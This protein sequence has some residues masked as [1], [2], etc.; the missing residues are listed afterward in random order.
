MFVV[1]LQEWIHKLEVGQGTRYLKFLL[2]ALAMTSLALVYDGRALRNLSTAEAMDAAQLA[3]HLAEGKGYTTQ[4]VRPLSIYLLQRHRPDHD[5]QVRVAHPDLANPPVYPLLVAGWMKVTPFRYGIPRQLEFSSYQPDVL[6]AA[7]NQALFFL[8][9]CMM[10]CLA[11]R[12]FDARV[13]WTSALV[14]AGTDLFWR[15]SVSGLSTLLLVILALAL[16]WCLALLDR[17]EQ[18]GWTEFRLN[19]VAAAAGALVGLGGLTR[20]A[21]GWVVL[22]V[23]FFLISFFGRKG[24]SLALVALGAF[25]LVLGPWVARNVL[26]SGTPFGTAGFALCAGTPSFPDDRLER[27]LHPDIRQVELGDCGQKL[28]VN[29][30]E[31]IQNDLPKLGG[32]WISA[33]FLAS[34]LV[35]F[36]SRTLSR[37]RWFLVVGLAVLSVA[38]ALGRTHLS[39]ESP[40][41]NSENLL[42]VLAPLV[43]VFGVA[44]FFILLD[45]FPLPFPQ[46]R[47][48]VPGAFAVLATAPLILTLLLPRVSAVVY[49]PYDPPRIQQSALLVD[50]GSLMISDVP[51]AVAWYGQR[52]CLSLTLDTQQDFLEVYERKRVRALYLSPRTTDR[53][54]VTELVAGADQGWGRLYLEVLL[55][56]EIP[57]GFPLKDG[58]TGYLP[59]QLFLLEPA[60]PADRTD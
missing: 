40:E 37:L 24:K 17:G 20:Y 26:V 50:D 51:W 21:F 49:P 18:S 32:N 15:F 33:F 9:V 42:V 44:L 16:V 29:L 3:R 56:K 8:A 46:A 28:L 48:W 27:S 6:I 55:K 58:K 53:R 41:V 52:Q 60:G 14:F 10:F 1:R 36:V 30:R 11:R 35:P 39:A 22:P 23:A 57:T 4:F 54:F 47:L 45:Q 13:A 2:S 19:L 5:P 12:L 25:A 43:L 38:Q 59:E 7:L 31:I 34:L